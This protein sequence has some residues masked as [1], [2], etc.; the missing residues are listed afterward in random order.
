PL[1]RE[2]LGTPGPTVK[3]TAPPVD[4]A[5]GPSYT[6]VLPIPRPVSFGAP[7][8]PGRSP[9]LMYRNFVGGLLLI[10]LAGT[11]IPSWATELVGSGGIGACG[12]SLLFVQDT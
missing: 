3:A 8:P 5:Q 1:G 2:R 12:G 7:A 10:L 9:D 6:A 11:S 4:A